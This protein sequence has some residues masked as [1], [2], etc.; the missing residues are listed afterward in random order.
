MNLQNIKQARELL[1]EEVKNNVDL[2]ETPEYSTLCEC[3]GLLDSLIGRLR[4]NE[5]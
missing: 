5:K 1:F 4:K 2:H 3:N